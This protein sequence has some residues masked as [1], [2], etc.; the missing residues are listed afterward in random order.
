MSSATATATSAAASATSTAAMSMGGSSSCKI[1]M[2]WNWY[3][4][5]TCFLAR[6]WH[7]HSK[8][9]FA[10]SCIGVIFLVISLELLRRLQREFDRYLHRLNGT[11]TTACCPGAEAGSDA[12]S[13]K[14]LGLNIPTFVR[15]SGVGHLKLWQQVARAALFTV[16]FAVGYFVMLLAMYYN[17]YIIICIFIGAFLGAIIFQWDTYTRV[18]GP[19]TR[20]SCCN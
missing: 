4:V 2:L 17:G 1:S 13:S 14:G 19:E 9:A 16:Q 15:R 18:E 7:V 8:G 3:T 12:G 11:V 6:S 20:D 10:G 5:D